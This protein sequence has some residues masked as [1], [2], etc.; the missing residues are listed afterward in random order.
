MLAAHPSSAPV[1]TMR[2]K[3]PIDIGYIATITLLNAR[4][5][6]AAQEASGAFCV[7]ERPTKG[8][9]SAP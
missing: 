7:G 8:H 4:R 1:L 6:E 3:L 5:M 2:Q 9:M